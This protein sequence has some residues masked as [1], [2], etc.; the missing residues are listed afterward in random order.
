MWGRVGDT[1]REM[2]RIQAHVLRTQRKEELL[3][4]LDDLKRELSSLRVAKVA[5]GAASKL[6]KIR[7]VRKSIARVLTV[8]NQNQRDA[9]RKA[10]AGQKYKPLDIRHKKTRA[11]RRKLTVG[12]ATARTERQRKRESY[13]PKRKYAV[14]A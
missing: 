14:L 7:E 5:G 10:Y 8:Y 9:L 6:A 3:K 11:H 4:Q 13:F 12:Q 1:E 2:A